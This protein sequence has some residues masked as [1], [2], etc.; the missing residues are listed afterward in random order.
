MRTSFDQ[1]GHNCV[2][3]ARDVPDDGAVLRRAPLPNRPVR[4]PW[5]R[6]G[7][8]GDREDGPLLRSGEPPHARSGCYTRP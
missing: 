6:D 7:S 2:V 1:Q 4:L 3:V 8:Y 5:P